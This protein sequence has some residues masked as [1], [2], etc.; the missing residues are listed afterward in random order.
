MQQRPTTHDAE[1]PAPPQPLASWYA[2]G[3]SDGLGDRL[4]MFD[5]STAPSLELLRFRAD[6]AQ[7]P[8]FEAAL[9][10]QVRRL[11]RFQHPA[12]ARVRS[13]Q[14]LEPDDDLA[15]ISNV[16][17]GKR[18]SE[19]LHRTRGPVF[20]AALIRQ[21]APALALL[22]QQSA[23]ISHGLLSPDR[24]VVSPEGRL[25]IV[26]HVVGP[27]IDALDLRIAQLASIG[28]AVPPSHDGAAP[29][30]DAATD[31]YQLGLVAV[32]V[33]IG[34]PVT[35]GEL[36]EL[37]ALL[38]RLGDSPG[39]D[40]AALSPLLRQWLG[41]ALQISGDRIGSGADAHAALDE[42]LRS[43]QPREARRIES[44]RVISAP[45]APPVSS[46]PSQ[47]PAPAILAS[48]LAES[49]AASV[50]MPDVERHD[51]PAPAPIAGPETAAAPVRT[52]KIESIVEFRAAREVRQPA[53]P[54]P[55]PRGD[56][57]PAA[58]AWPD[59]GRSAFELE[60]LAGKQRLLDL[61]R[62]LARNDAAAESERSSRAS[63]PGRSAVP[64]IAALAL[65]AVAEAG[66]IAW[67]ARAL[68]FAPHPPIAVA[69]NASGENVLVTASR[70]R[71]M[72]MVPATP[73]L[74]TML[75]S[76]R[77]RGPSWMPI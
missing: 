29:R 34:R 26:E 31:W 21:L 20:A 54:S 69:A 44:P 49:G 37:E 10:E 61:E 67:L 18:L 53:P 59:A 15:L 6:L 62:R 4:L 23:G 42:V 19:V 39:T 25:T 24:I 13:V 52:A 16:T 47:P 14:R 56:V 60:A 30:L 36:P 68:W 33:L 41:R 77:S 22:Q 65:L 64:V 43:E 28:I 40:G 17:P 74:A 35:A 38:D 57:R 46:A 50:T 75:G 70:T 76:T 72:L 45:S 55:A 1:V 5:N 12:F 7:A 58:D 8:G 63:K 48:D 11:A 3:V 2:Q 9:R 27:A 73:G 51:E 66:V 32:S 71:T